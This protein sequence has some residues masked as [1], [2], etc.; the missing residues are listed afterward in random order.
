MVDIKKLLSI[1][2]DHNAIIAEIPWGRKKKKIK[3]PPPSEKRG[4][5]YKRNLTKEQKETF[6]ERLTE[7]LKNIDLNNPQTDLSDILVEIISKIAP[8]DPLAP[9]KAIFK[10]RGLKIK[11][12]KQ[13][14]KIMA[15]LMQ[16]KPLNDKQKD[17]IQTLN[18]PQN[19]EPELGKK[20]KKLHNEIRRYHREQ[21]NDAFIKKKIRELRKEGEQP[22]HLS[23]TKPFVANSIQDLQYSR[24]SL[25]KHSLEEKKRPTQVTRAS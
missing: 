12:H 14:G 10:E 6:N 4:L 5:P 16:N 25:Q 18:D 2:T 21:L 1:P 9:P 8:A 11:E 15:K 19:P 23:S 22:R 17:Y 20:Q 7:R 24:L 13:I 3:P